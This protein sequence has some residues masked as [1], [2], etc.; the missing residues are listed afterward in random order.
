MNTLTKFASFVLSAAFLAASV[1]L[2]AAEKNHQAS[3]AG[4]SR[5]QTAHAVSHGTEIGT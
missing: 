3:A 5:R 1:N 4:Q 2:C